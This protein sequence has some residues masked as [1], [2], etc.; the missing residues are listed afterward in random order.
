MILSVDSLSGIGRR[1]F[2]RLALLLKTVDRKDGT[3]KH[4]KVAY[5]AVDFNRPTLLLKSKTTCTP[6]G[7]MQLRQAASLHLALSRR[8]SL[9][10]QPRCRWQE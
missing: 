2:V 3:A 9:R 1:A 10:R 7:T 6:V 8:A 5:R 4:P